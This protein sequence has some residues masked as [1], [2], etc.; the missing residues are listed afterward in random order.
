MCLS[1][2][3]IKKIEVGNVV[4]TKVGSVVYRNG[5]PH[6]LGLVEKVNFMIKVKG[7]LIILFFRLVPKLRLM[8]KRLLM[9]SMTPQPPAKRGKLISPHLMRER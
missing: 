3:N 4:S 5:F 7:Y 6:I 1:P 8:L 9:V 2:K